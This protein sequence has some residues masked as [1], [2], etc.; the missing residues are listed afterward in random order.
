MPT[1]LRLY[2]PTDEAVPL[3]AEAVIP[4]IDG[5]LH[6]VR[7]VMRRAI[8]D[9]VEVF[10]GRDG[11]FLGEIVDLSKRVGAIKLLEQ[12][13][14]PVKQRPIMVCF[15]V[16][17]RTPMEVLV[18]KVTELGCMSLQPMITQRTTA[19][20]FN[21]ERLTAI[22]VEAAEQCERLNVPV[23]HKPLPLEDCLNTITGLALYADEGDDNED[24]RW[25]KV[26]ENKNNA[27]ARSLITVLDEEK[28]MLC[29]DPDRPI[30][31]LI[32]PEGGFTTQE[33]S[34]LRSHASLYAVRLGPRILR[35]ETAA[36]AALSVIQA[37]VGDW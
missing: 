37:S 30:T 21:A 29:A 24:G 26:N 10:N 1:L 12:S 25:A 11:A 14:R 27:A 20:T 4:L 36:I 23:L 18:Q 13:R 31:V 35:A 15:S 7:S 32:G 3:M 17:K 34:M 6:Y 8:G 16:I 9:R 5:Q 28:S 2:I 19:K 22:A 33:Q